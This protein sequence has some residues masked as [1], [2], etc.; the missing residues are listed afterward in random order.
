M[1]AMPGQYHR[2][3]QVGQLLESIP[4]PLLQATLQVHRIAPLGKLSSAAGL[5]K[6][7]LVG[8]PHASEPLSM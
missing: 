3:H 7:D 1:R 4:L 6:L 8:L 5:V 2:C